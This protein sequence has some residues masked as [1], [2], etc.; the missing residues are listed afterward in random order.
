[1]PISGLS[2]KFTFQSAAL[3]PDTLRVLDFQGEEKISRLFRYEINLTSDL[4]DIDLQAVLEQ[5]A[6]LSLE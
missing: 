6:F 4:P 1:M 2:T 3:E 5:P